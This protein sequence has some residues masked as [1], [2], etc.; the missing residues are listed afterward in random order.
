MGVICSNIVVIHVDRHGKSKQFQPDNREWVTAIEY[1]GNDGFIL[2]PFLMREEV[3]TFR[4]INI[5]FLKCCKTK[6][7]YI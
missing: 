1:V 4:K 5:V 7:T 3:R 6:R 2:P